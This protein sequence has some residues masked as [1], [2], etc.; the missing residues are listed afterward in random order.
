MLTARPGAVEA[1]G[2]A[3]RCCRSAGSVS[4]PQA[5]LERRVHHDRIPELAAPGSPVPLSSARLLGKAALA[6]QRD[7]CSTVCK[8]LQAQLWA[9]SGREPSRSGLHERRT[10]TAP[11]T[12]GER[13]QL[14][15]SGGP[16]RAAIPMIWP[17][18]TAATSPPTRTNSAALASTSTGGSV[19][20]PR[21]PRHRHQLRHR[22]R[23]ARLPVSPRPA[24]A[25]YARA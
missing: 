22:P 11:T 18:A 15:R 12:V 7:R 24:P 8:H 3:D 16:R 10:D 17:S 19:A 4:T 25:A 5:T 13:C 23:I 9:A 1:A 20:I 21:L 14:V 6:V 2:R